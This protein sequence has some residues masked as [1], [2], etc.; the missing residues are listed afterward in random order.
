MLALYL[1]C[2]VAG[3]DPTPPL[4]TAQLEPDTKVR[5][6][7]VWAGNGWRTGTVE[8]PDK[9][10]MIHLDQPLEAGYNRIALLALSRL[11]W[12]D[13]AG[14]WQELDLGELLAHEPTGCR[15]ESTL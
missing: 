6:Q 8:E 15:E 1:T 12:R 7:S 14:K 5:L 11:Q 10:T 2:A 4:P 13:G 3:A 9:C